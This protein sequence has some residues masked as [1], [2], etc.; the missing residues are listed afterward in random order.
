MVSVSEPDMRNAEENRS[1]AFGDVW[2][3]QITVDVVE[4]VMERIPIE[5]FVHLIC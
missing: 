3:L 5:L 1:E 2:F 4:A